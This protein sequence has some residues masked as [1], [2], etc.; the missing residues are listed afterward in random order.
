MGGLQL[1]AKKHHGFPAAPWSRERG[2]GRILPLSLRTEPIPADTLTL[3][4]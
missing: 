2:L 4:F 3:D 1:L